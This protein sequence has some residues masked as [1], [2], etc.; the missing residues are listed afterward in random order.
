[1][2]WI[3]TSLVPEKLKIPM[4]S[5][6]LKSL[7][8]AST[9]L[10]NIVD[11]FL[12]QQLR[13]LFCL[14]KLIISKDGQKWCADVLDFFVTAGQTLSPGHAETRRYV[15]AMSGQ[16][17]AVLNIYCATSNPTP[18]KPQVKNTKF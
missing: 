14:G 5:V 9:L 15:A 8:L 12:C 4:V 3:P 17:A 1:M 7:S 6:S 11:S 10:V 16:S 13:I 18:G 2:D